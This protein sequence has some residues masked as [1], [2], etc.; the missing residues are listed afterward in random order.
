MLH[1]GGIPRLGVK[2]FVFVKGTLRANLNT[3]VGCNS[4]I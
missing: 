2:I 3:T 4:K 1:V